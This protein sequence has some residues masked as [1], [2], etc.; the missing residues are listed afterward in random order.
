MKRNVRIG[1]VIVAALVIVL[2]AASNAYA[3][4]SYE[5]NCASCHDDPTGMTISAVSSID[6][7]PGATFQVDVV[8]TGLSQD[9]FKLRIPQDVDD[10][11]QFTV[12]VPADALYPG[13]VVDNDGVYDLDPTANSIHTIYNL[14]APSF[15]GEYTLTI[16][17][18]QH[19]P[20]GIETSITVNVAGGG[21]GPSIGSPSTTP[22]V[23]RANEEFTVNVTVTSNSTLNYV[24]LQYSTD[25]GTS[26]QN[27]TM[28]GS[29]DV[30]TGAIPGFPKNQKV[31]WRI[32]A[33]DS[34]GE[35]VS[36][37]Q[38]YVVGQIQVEPIAIPQYHYGWLFGAPAIV[39]A[40]IGIALEYYDEERFTKIHGIMLG[41]AYI[42][43]GINVISLV[44]E[45]AAIW[46]AMNPIYLFNLANIV[47]FMHS[48]HIWLGIIS[49]IFGTLALITHL[50]GWKT[51]NFGLPAVVLWTI[52][53][54]M[55]VYLG[56]IFVP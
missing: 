54:I 31:L 40:Y 45:P 41:V 26:W 34:T 5:S 37:T 30:Y 3:Y 19:R 14:T 36:A 10:N 27:V 29:G 35:R 2:L 48:L 20:E 44:T 46:A 24:R 56:G 25:D 8:A 15:S 28:S 38:S 39:I 17:A 49:M 42:L 21:A 52:L 1:L 11:S 47:M 6:V 4:P 12:V 9:V 32:V 33:A 23:P 7:E 22:Q 50:G 53:G 18:C 51:C 55:G 43:T 16:W 13:L